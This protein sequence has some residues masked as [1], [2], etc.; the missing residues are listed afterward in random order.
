MSPFN[1]REK[2]VLCFISYKAS[3]FCYDLTEMLWIIIP[4]FIWALEQNHWIPQ[5]VAASHLKFAKYCLFIFGVYQPLQLASH[6]VVVWILLIKLFELRYQYSSSRTQKWPFSIAR[7]SLH[8]ILSW[9]K[10]QS[11][12]WWYLSTHSSIPSL[13]APP[14]IASYHRAFHFYY[15]YFYPTFL[16]HLNL[17]G[18]KLFD[19]LRCPPIKRSI[20]F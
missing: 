1:F 19:C 13:M 12:S 10:L 4:S 16:S 20:P 15:F 14:F 7:Q 2:W 9:L 8:P 5:V 3:K 17:V 11:N 18:S 6:F